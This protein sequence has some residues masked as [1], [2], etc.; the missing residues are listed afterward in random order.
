M[1]RVMAVDDEYM[2]LRG[3][4]KLID[5]QALGLTIVQ[6]EQNPV[7]ALNYLQHEPIDILLSDMNM[8]EMAGPEFLAA[9][10]RLQPNMQIIVLSGYGDFDYVKAGLEQG[11]INYLRKPIDPDELVRTLQKALRQLAQHDTA[12][13]NAQLAHQALTREL[14]TGRQEARFDHAAEGLQLNLPAAAE[15][16]LLAI[17]NPLQRTALQEDLAT[18][19]EVAGYFSE[20]Q[21]VIVLFTG[22]TMQVRQFLDQLPDSVGPTRRPV[23]VSPVIKD[24]QAIADVYQRVRWA[25]NRRY[26]FAVANGLVMLPDKEAGQTV[27][28]PSVDTLKG[29]LRDITPSGLTD[30][31]KRRFDQM[32]Q[33][34][35]SVELTRQVAVIILLAMRA[36]HPSYELTSASF[37]RIN[38]AATVADL[39][40]VLLETAAA[41]S[42]AAQKRY[43]RNVTEVLAIIQ[44]RFK[45]PLTLGEIAGELHLSPVYLG[46]QFK[47]EVGQTVAQYLNDYRI[48]Q[49]IQLLERTEMDVNEIAHEVGYQT[50]SYFFKTFKKQLNM[51]PGEY[52]EVALTAPSESGSDQ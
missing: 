51:S 22:T 8:P 26:F 21:D 37:G 12:D 31:L 44:S 28:L 4:P 40:T 23:I 29:E 18:Q 7:A 34:D 49:A 11:A 25:I 35:A 33:E 20:G 5:W 36:L 16:R 2:I 24:H 42:Q 13:Q 48:N 52:R 6:T 46:Q 38:N 47:K 10:R 30:W 39:T 19:R 1:K 3:I 15:W 45:E 32:E 9:A 27:K 17:L 50:A 41:M 14:V 43:S